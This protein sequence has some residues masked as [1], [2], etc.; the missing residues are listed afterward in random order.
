MAAVS[1]VFWETA[2]LFSTWL[3][4]FTLPTDDISLSFSTPSPSTWYGQFFL[5]ILISMLWYL[6]VVLICIYI[7]KDNVKHLF[8]CFLST[9]IYLLLC[10]FKFCAQFLIRLLPYNWVLSILYIFWSHILY[11][12]QGFANIYSQTMGYLFI[13]LGIF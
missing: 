3:Y 10:L 9:Y 4:H 13:F 7:M 1:S 8:M 2:K 5:T 11:Y 12:I 6:T